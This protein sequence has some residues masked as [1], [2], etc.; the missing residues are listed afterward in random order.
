MFATPACRIR[1][2]TF[3]AYPKPRSRSSIHITLYI[4]LLCLDAHGLLE[5]IQAR[6]MTINAGLE[7]EGK[8]PLVPKNSSLEGSCDIVRTRG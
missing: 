8:G 6:L 4:R 1:L 3:L 2:P 7:P 5:R